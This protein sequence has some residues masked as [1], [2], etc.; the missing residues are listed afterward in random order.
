MCKFILPLALFDQN[1]DQ[2]VE[3]RDDEGDFLANDLC[4]QILLY[5]GWVI[6]LVYVLT[7]VGF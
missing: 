7:E 1:A 2:D 3:V 5:F 6:E 4:A